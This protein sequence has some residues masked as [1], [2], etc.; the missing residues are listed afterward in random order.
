MSAQATSVASGYSPETDTLLWKGAQHQGWRV[1]QVDDSKFFLS[2]DGIGYVSRSDVIKFEKSGGGSVDRELSPKAS[3]RSKRDQHVLHHHP[4]L[5]ST[6][7]NGEK[8]RCGIVVHTFGNYESPTQVV[9]PAKSKLSSVA[10]DN[11]RLQLP[12]NYLNFALEKKKNFSG[13]SHVNVQF[14][15][16]ARMVAAGSF[17]LGDN[18][19]HFYVEVKHVGQKKKHLG[20]FDTNVGAALCYAMYKKNNLHV[21]PG[22]GEPSGSSEHA[23]TIFDLNDSED[24]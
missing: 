11:E 16:R 21:T 22:V 19:K 9:S 7:T 8:D 6:S 14:E 13:Y 1:K 15:S 3:K 17:H 4:L 20:S 2:P 18:K 12:D 10:L 24:E 23:P 5:D